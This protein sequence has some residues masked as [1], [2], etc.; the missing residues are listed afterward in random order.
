MSEPASPTSAPSSYQIMLR[1]HGTA[2][3]KRVGAARLAA[4]PARGAVIDV[5][6]AGRQLRG[7]VDAVFIPPGCEE[8]CVGTI[9]LSEA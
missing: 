8:N 1:T 7:V 6:C 4:Q 9:F 3:F 5:E 2:D